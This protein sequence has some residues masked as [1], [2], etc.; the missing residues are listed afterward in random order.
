MPSASEPLLISSSLF[1]FS[2]MASHFR[3]NKLQNAVDTMA[4][5]ASLYPPSALLTPPPTL[6]DPSSSNPARE[7]KLWSSAYPETSS[8]E[9]VAPPHLTFKGITILYQ[10]F[11]EKGQKATAET[12]RKVCDTY[13]DALA[14]RLELDEALLGTRKRRRGLPGGN[15]LKSG[16][17]PPARA[18]SPS[19]RSTR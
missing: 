17:P 16:L 5:F 4:E 3:S 1:S 14:G 13:E 11:V 18:D 12:V 15:N 8:F 10:R 9:L 7:V 2:N 19:T 6:D